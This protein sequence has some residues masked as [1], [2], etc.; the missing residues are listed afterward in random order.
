MALFPCFSILKKQGK[1]GL[2]IFKN[3]LF[4]TK[5]RFKHTFSKTEINQIGY[6]LTKNS[7]INCYF[8]TICTS[9]FSVLFF[10]LKLLFENQLIRLNNTEIQILTINYIKK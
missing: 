1:K 9:V 2:Q 6:S 4:L 8:T 3:S 7:K 10:V 5:N